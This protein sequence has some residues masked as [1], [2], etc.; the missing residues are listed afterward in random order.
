MFL[1][2]QEKRCPSIWAL[3]NEQPHPSYPWLLNKQEHHN[4]L[5]VMFCWAAKHT[6]GRFLWIPNQSCCVGVGCMGGI[7]LYDCTTKKK[8][9]E[10][11]LAT[12]V[13]HYIMIYTP[14]KADDLH[15]QIHISWQRQESA[16]SRYIII[17][18]FFLVWPC[19]W[20]MIFKDIK[21]RPFI[22]CITC[23]PLHNLHWNLTV[24]HCMQLLDLAVHIQAEKKNHLY[25]ST[26]VDMATAWF[27]G[28]PL[29]PSLYH[30]HLRGISKV[31]CTITNPHIQLYTSPPISTPPCPTPDWLY[32]QSSTPPPC[33]TH[34]TPYKIWDWSVGHG[35]EGVPAFS[36]CLQT[37]S[38]KQPSTITSWQRHTHVS[39]HTITCKHTAKQTK[40]ATKQPHSST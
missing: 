25:L 23:K 7:T 6:L 10:Q 2:G 18:P 12:V 20:L 1:A 27:V 9:A 13:A 11:C 35:W 40:K 24:C 4:K 38:K 26:W 28:E 29:L 14:Y 36:A 3:A 8:L 33:S 31:A 15:L 34:H 21:W 22:S 32:L 16:E 5:W 17:V 19:I 39:K 30:P 37:K